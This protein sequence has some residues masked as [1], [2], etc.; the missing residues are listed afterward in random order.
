MIGGPLAQ[1]HLVRQFIELVGAS[2]EGFS[3]SPASE[4]TSGRLSDALALLDRLPLLEPGIAEATKS[5]AGD[6]VMEVL[7]GPR[8]WVYECLASIR[9]ERVLQRLVLRLARVSLPA[10]AQVLHGP[11]EHGKDVAVMLRA[12]ET[13]EVRMYQVKV[14]KIDTRVWRAAKQELEVM[15]DVP[16]PALLTGGQTPDRVVGYLV[17]NDHAGPNVQ[18]EMDGWFATQRELLGRELHFLHIDGLVRWIYDDRLLAEF[19]AFV[20]DEALC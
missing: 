15:F 7:L 6:R 10:Y 3:E 18:P 16:L 11:L 20:L 2:L 5:A 13:A 17:T 19:R 4:I 9:D 1:D 12:G 14:G 8:N